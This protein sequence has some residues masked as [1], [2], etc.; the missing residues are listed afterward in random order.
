MLCLGNLVFTQCTDLILGSIPKEYYTIIGMT[1]QTEAT[2][3]LEK[4]AEFYLITVLI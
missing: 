2:P 1:L 3:W 4:M